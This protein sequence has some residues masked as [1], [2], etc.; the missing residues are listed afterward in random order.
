MVTQNYCTFQPYLH[1]CERNQT[2]RKSFRRSVAF[3]AYF[4]P[5]WCPCSSCCVCTSGI[6]LVL[7]VDQVDHF[8]LVD[9]S[10]SYACLHACRVAGWWKCSPFPKSVTQHWKV[11]LVTRTKL[12]GAPWSLWP[13]SSSFSAAAWKELWT[14]SEVTALTPEQRGRHD[15]I[16]C[17]HT[18]W[19]CG[20]KN[21]LWVKYN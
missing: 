18:Q 7:C 4:L 6:V 12:H 16:T 14:H 15:L 5:C 3:M 8:L 2:Q 9:I 21:Y 13:L 20:T 11:C 1:Y 10:F 19:S 17:S